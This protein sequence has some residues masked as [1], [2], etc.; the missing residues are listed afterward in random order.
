LLLEG[1]IEQVTFLEDE[2][3]EK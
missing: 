3:K 1:I 2:Q